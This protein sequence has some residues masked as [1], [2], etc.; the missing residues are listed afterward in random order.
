M[1]A[2]PLDPPLVTLQTCASSASPFEQNCAGGL[3]THFGHSQTS[4]SSNGSTATAAASLSPAGVSISVQA[5]I[6]PD[7]E[8]DYNQAYGASTVDYEIEVIGP[9]NIQL[10]VGIQADLSVSGG[11]GDAINVAGGTADGVF[12][13]Q[14]LG[15]AFLEQWTVCTQTELCNSPSH[16]SINTTATF[17]TNQLYEV[18]EQV[19]ANADDGDWAGGTADPYFFL[20]GDAQGYS[21]ITSDG[22]GNVPAGGVPE[23]AAWALMLLGFGAAGGAIRRR[24]TGATATA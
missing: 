15:P 20:T 14:G 22:V 11:G 8:A 10:Q 5:A 19:S 21:I 23:P 7:G 3:G 12:K 17:F 2:Q 6:S 16:L 9:E 18:I 24:R 1:A 13:V 4:T